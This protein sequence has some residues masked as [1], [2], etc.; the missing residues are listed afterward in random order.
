MKILFVLSYGV[1]IKNVIGWKVV[2]VFFC[3]NLHLIGSSERP[4]MV[5]QRNHCEMDDSDSKT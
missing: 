3:I 4:A 2:S 1:I 5:A